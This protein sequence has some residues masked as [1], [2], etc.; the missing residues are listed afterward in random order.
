MNPSDPYQSLLDVLSPASRGVLGVPAAPSTA[1]FLSTF[2]QDGLTPD[3]LAAWGR[4]EQ[5][6]GT[7]FNI[8]SAYRDP[9]HNARVGGARN[10]QHTHG[11]AFD[12]DVSHLSESERVQLIDYAR[13]SGFGGVGVYNNSLHFD[14]GPTRYWG[15]DYSAGSLP[16]WAAEAVGAPRGAFET[17]AGGEQPMPMQ[18]RTSTSG[19]SG[20]LGM[21]T[22]RASTP[23]EDSLWSRLTG[24]E[25]P[26]AFQNRP[27]FFADEDKMARLA[28]GLQGM[29]T[30]P[31]QQ[32]MAGLQS[33]IDQRGEAR[34]RDAAAQQAQSQ[35]AQTRTAALEYLMQ[36][37][38][39]QQ[40]IEAVGAGLIDPAQAVQM[41][42]AP[43]EQ[44]AA[45]QNYEYLI[46]QGVPEAEARERAFNSG[47]VNID[48]GP[49]GRLG[50]VPSGYVAVEDPNSTSGY[51]MVAIEGG[52]AAQSQLQAEQEAAAAVERQAL[53]AQN[54]QV[55]GDVV[56]EDLGRARD[57]IQG[58]GRLNPAA[59]LGAD[60]MSNVGGSNAANV[61]NLLMTVRSNI[62]F[63]R[64]QQM[65]EAS[66]TGGALGN[67]T[68]RELANL[69]SV[70]GS[71]EQNQSPEQLLANIDRLE[72]IYTQIMQ[73]AAAYPNASD[74]GFGG[75]SGGL[76]P[77]P[78]GVTPDT[79]PRI[80]E[81]MTPEQKAMFQ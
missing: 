71:L 10:S 61:N 31:N 52:P 62:G 58:A 70:L 64:L 48:M 56:L 53:S 21:L 46:G 1:G 72:T 75:T 9:G 13:Q 39:P 79:W 2:E 12:V 29:T 35:A 20:L 51:R 44:T 45:Q 60:M 78:N 36:N 38:A 19:Q 33:G 50:S 27:D 54:T 81:A 8:N 18:S 74:F 5:M 28:I 3:A 63:D 26:G 37:G 22:G 17:A 30:R 65:R 42:M 43:R 47:G 32:M 59:G 6:A 69:Q 14:V 77:V 68:E 57:L 7:P 23:P 15:P 67:V 4:F 40:I 34:S 16:S 76:P 49:D 80:Y 55:V 11:N 41:A 66:P 25:L 73:K 24:Q